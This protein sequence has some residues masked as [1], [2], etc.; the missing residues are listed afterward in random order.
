MNKATTAPAVTPTTVPTGGIKSGGTLRVG[1]VGRKQ[2]A[3]PTVLDQLLVPAD[4]GGNQ[5][6]TLGHSL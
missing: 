4:V 1:I 2:H 6:A 5:Q 3:G